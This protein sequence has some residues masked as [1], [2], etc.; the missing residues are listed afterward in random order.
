MTTTDPH[1]PLG[2]LTREQL[3]EWCEQHGER[4]FR[5]D[6]I[7][8]WLFGKRVSDFSEM[9]DVP[10]KL[11]EELSSQFDVLSSKI[12]RHQVSSDRTEKLLLELADGRWVWVI[13]KWP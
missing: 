12:T 2:N 8:K 9:H 3:A 7:R 10:A 5:A 11:R 6:Q 13:R 1:K 4:G